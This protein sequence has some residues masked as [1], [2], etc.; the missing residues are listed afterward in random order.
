M[1]CHAFVRFTGA[2]ILACSTATVVGC[3]QGTPSGPETQQGTQEAGFSREVRGGRFHAVQLQ[4]MP[5]DER[6]VFRAVAADLSGELATL[7]A[8][9]FFRKSQVVRPSPGGATLRYDVMRQHV[10]G[11]PI[12]GSYLNVVLRQSDSVAPAKILASSYRVFQSPEVD[13]ASKIGEGAAISAAKTVIRRANAPVR[14]AELEIWPVNGALRLVWNVTFLGSY[15][16]AL[17]FANGP[18]IGRVHVIDERIYETDGT[19]S[20]FVTVGGAP[21][22]DGVPTSS[23]MG[24]LTVTAGAVT[25]TTDA[26]GAFNI[27]AT[28]DLTATLSGTAVNVVDQAGA[29]LSLTSPADAVVELVFGS[30]TASANEIAQINT[31]FY[32]TAIRDFL[33][34]NGVPAE[35]LVTITAN[36]NVNDACNAFF[37]PAELS[38]NLFQ[39]GEVFGTKCNNTAEETIIYHEYGHFV[40]H[41]FG[42][43]IDGGLSEGWGDLIAC[44]AT[45][46][47]GTGIDLFVDDDAPLRTCDNDY[48]FPASGS[49]EVHAL[50]Q[51]WAG[52]GWHAREGLIAELGE[53]EGDA[54]ARALLLPSFAS[55][56][57]D[58][59]SAVREVFLRDDDD[60]DLSNLTPHWDILLEAANRHS[61]GFVVDGDLIAPS[62]VA[63][64]AVSEVSATSATLTWTASGDDDA[65][66]T[67]SRYDI[68]ALGEPITPENFTLGAA[69]PGPVPTEAGTTQ[70]LTIPLAPGTTTFVALKV[71][72]EENNGSDISNVVEITTEEGTVVFED[73]AEGG[74]G[75]WV[76]TGLWHVTETAASEGTK[77]FWYGQEA[78]GNYDTPG[79][80]NSGTLTSPVI[81]LTGIENPVL[82]FDQLLD[83][84]SSQSFDQAQV[85]V[86]DVNDPTVEIIAA[87]EKGNTFGAFETRFVALTGLGGRQV[88]IELSFD[89]VDSVA[90]TGQGWL[91]DVVKIVGDGELPGSEGSL[92]VNEVLADPG[93][94]DSNGDGNSNVRDDEF[95]ELVNVGDGPL[96][97]TGVVIEDRVR[98]RFAFP[99]GVTLAPGEVAVVFGA[100]APVI[101]GVKTFASGG[102]FLNNN[103]DDLTV[104]RADGEV[105]AVMS[106]GCCEGRQNQSLNRQVDADSESPFVLHTSIAGLVASPGLQADGAAFPGGGDPAPEV[107]LVINELLTDPPSG[108]DANGD[109]DAN[110]ATD[111][112][113]ELVNAGE[114]AIDLSGA[115]LSDGVGVRLVFPDG[116]VMAPGSAL[117]V[118]GGGTPTGDFGGATVL[119]APALIQLNNDGD[120]ITIRNAGGDILAGAS[121]DSLL[122]GQNQAIVRAVE[123]DG[124]S[125]WVFHAS[126]GEGPASPGTRADGTPF[127]TPE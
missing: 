26:A 23:A 75:E 12:H 98:V 78:T 127:G 38:L 67:A 61:L 86:F 35:D 6:E 3:A 57:P 85:R 60:G 70:T 68:R 49:D 113:V 100:G 27:D 124:D 51:A 50:G 58:I 29:T 115:T 46:Q 36:A 17:V 93:D 116:T 63:D 122:G 91:V 77:S 109:G 41:Q 15:E 7:S 31:Y 1:N 33:I 83:I 8:D 76:A 72:D 62:A 44:L 73:G 64:L 4:A 45:K 52:F 43:I 19:V 102:L 105:L 5:Q 47:P 82:A 120:T 54:L 20:G 88:Q 99:D 84:E 111:E 53:A 66:G 39:A 11:I 123:G 95:I 37:S 16:R 56:A 25:A 14:T 18:A 107:S 34:A 28:E 80:A 112:F 106:Y 117:V 110:Y 103:G 104:R 79:E 59:P 81:D 101:A 90:N 118:F 55:N 87:K 21:G 24:S 92:M 97:L 96:D 74:L 125:E 69:I 114:T 13:T 126:V 32:V 9:D 108:Y 42:G 2:A 40:D 121:Y 10:D 71:F 94:F 119:T 48:Q 22:G 65:T 89:T 30:D